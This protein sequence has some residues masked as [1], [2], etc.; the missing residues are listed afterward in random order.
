MYRNYV[1]HEYYIRP[2]FIFKMHD[3]MNTETLTIHDEFCLKSSCTNFHMCK[4]NGD[5]AF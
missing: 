4:N 3:S 1:L 5:L 2:H